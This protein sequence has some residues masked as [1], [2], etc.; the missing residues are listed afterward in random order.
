MNRGPEA[1]MSYVE[2]KLVNAAGRMAQL[3]GTDIF[4]DGQGQQSAV[5]NLDGFTASIDD[6][7]F[8]VEKSEYLL[9]NPSIREYALA[10]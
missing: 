3:L 2:S 4:L 1:A 6:G 5:I 7:K 10:A 9:E 8:A